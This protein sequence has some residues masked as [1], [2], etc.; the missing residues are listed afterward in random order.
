MMVVEIIAGLV[1]GSMALLADGLHMASPCGGA[2]YRGTGS[3]RL[4]R[5]AHDRGFVLVWQNQQPGGFTSAVLLLG[6]A[7]LMVTEC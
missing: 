4:R 6:F 2:G 3:R 1:Y 5:L 7:L